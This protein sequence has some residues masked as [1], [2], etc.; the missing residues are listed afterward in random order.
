[1]VKARREEIAYFRDMGIY[2]KVDINE[3]W[4]ETG[5]APIAVRW[6]DIG[7]GDT[8]NPKYRSR[9]VAKELKNPSVSRTICGDATQ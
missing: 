7:K 3:A 9:L 1:M 4:S 2:E 5:K 6:V 8:A